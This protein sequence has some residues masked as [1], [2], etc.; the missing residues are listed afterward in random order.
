[1]LLKFGVDGLRIKIDNRHVKEKETFMGWKLRWAI[2]V[3]VWER[4]S[5]RKSVHGRP[6]WIRALL[7]ESTVNALPFTRCLR[8]S[9]QSW[10]LF[11]NCMSV[12]LSLWSWDAR[13]SMG[14]WVSMARVFPEDSRHSL[15]TPAP[16]SSQCQPLSHSSCCR[17]GLKISLFNHQFYTIL[18][19]IL[20]H[21]YCIFYKVKIC[22]QCV[23]NGSITEL[24]QQHLLSFCVFVTFW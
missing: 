20:L 16:L 11:W 7:V 2:A 4:C 1:M 18:C 17:A 6:F 8:G 23:S 22:V 14:G 13:E 19:F 3:S 24:F 15:P 9:Q 5:F 10:D 12:S 21:K